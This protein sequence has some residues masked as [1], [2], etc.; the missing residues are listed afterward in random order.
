VLTLE[1]LP[2]GFE[3][4]PI[5]EFGLAKEDLSSDEFTVEGIFAFFEAERFEVVMG[6]TTLILTRLE[7]AGFDVSLRQP[8]SLM[9]SFIEG[10][11]ATEVLERE[12]LAHLNDIGDASTGLTLVAEIADIPMRMDVT[13]FRRDIVGAFVLVMYLEGDDPIVTLDEIANKLDD[14]IVEVLPLGD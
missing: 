3:A 9:E 13:I 5:D 10:M 12:E 6:F 4:I 7:Q 11:G 2:S 14:R 8:D 1:D